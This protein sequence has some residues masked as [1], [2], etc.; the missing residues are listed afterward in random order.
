MSSELA[1]GAPHARTWPSVAAL[2]SMA[3]AL[4]ASWPLIELALSTKSDL[5]VAAAFI[6]IPASFG[7]WVWFTI[8]A[9]HDRGLA[10]R[11]LRSTIGAVVFF[12]LAGALLIVWKLGEVAG[13]LLACQI[14]AVV[15]VL[16]L[17]IFN[18]LATR[19]V[20]LTLSLSS[21]QIVGG[22][23]A[24]VA[25]LVIRASNRTPQEIAQESLRLREEQFR[26]QQ[27]RDMRD[28]F[29]R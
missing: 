25:L 12:F 9:L 17:I 10:F 21:L 3:V 11:Q 22:L 1:D 28:D 26:Y 6:T 20:L 2:T 29:G 23:V 19:S 14:L 5:A 24:A 13:A 15:A 7:L 27:D 8:L 18:W 16:A 4:G